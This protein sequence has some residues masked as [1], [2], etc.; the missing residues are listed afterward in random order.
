[1]RFVTFEQDG[2]QGLAIEEQEGL[3]GLTVNDAGY[4]GDLAQLLK[5]G[6]ATLQKAHRRLGGGRSLEGE[7]IRFLP[8]L[9]RPAKI[10][11]V[12]LNYADHTKESPYDQPD[13]PTVFTRFASSLIGHNAPI[14]RP[15][16]SEQLDY[17][18]EMAVIIGTGGRNISRGRALD[19]VA[20]YSIFNDAS[21]RDYQFKSPQWTMG[22]NFDATG[23]FGPAFVTAEELPLGGKG[24][25]LRTLLNGEVVQQANT[26]DLIFDVADLISIISEVLTLEPGDVLVTGTP[27]GVGFARTPP[28]YM[29]EG[30]VCSVEVEGLGTLINP[31]SR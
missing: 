10:I 19:H 31:V 8:P 26:D 11:C 7:S 18:G 27:A 2:H 25:Q 4:P 13:Y 12:G 21:V 28:L 1:M 22:K 29:Q 5:E 17:E 23:A 24:L 16:G 6:E 14:I 3:R 9:P 30:D 20:G 15:A